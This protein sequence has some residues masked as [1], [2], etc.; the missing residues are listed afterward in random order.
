MRKHPGKDKDARDTDE[1]KEFSDELDD[2]EEETSLIGS[3]SVSEGMFR[4]ES[5]K[6]QY[7]YVGFLKEDHGVYFWGQYKSPPWTRS[8]N[9]FCNC[10]K[11]QSDNL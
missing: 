6:L 8:T 1:D 10:W 11:Q 3:T 4:S 5:S 2:R 7:R 9:S